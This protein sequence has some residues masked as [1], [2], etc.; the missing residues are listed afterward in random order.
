MI[1][2]NGRMCPAILQVLLW[3][4]CRPQPIPDEMINRESMTHAETF[5]FLSNEGLIESCTDQESC[6]FRTTA[7]GGALVN[8]LCATKLPIEVKKWVN[9]ATG[10]I[11]K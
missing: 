7:R 4:H 8:M 9:P 6:G 11:V 2:S 10:E 1:Y 3:I 5:K